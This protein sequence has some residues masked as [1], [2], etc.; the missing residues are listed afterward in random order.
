MPHCSKFK[1]EVRSLQFFIECGYVKNVHKKQSS[2]IEKLN[3]SEWIVLRN[4]SD[5]NI[6]EEVGILLWKVT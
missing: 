6:I 4:I 1:V 3:I 2:L 5:T